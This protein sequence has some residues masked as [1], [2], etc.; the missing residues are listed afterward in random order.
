[1]EDVFAV[2]FECENCGMEWE[3]TYPRRTAVRREAHYSAIVALDEDCSE[4]IQDCDC[5]HREVC[6]NCDLREHV[7]VSNR[8]PLEE[9]EA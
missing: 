9:A 4:F 5:C 8:R 7:T 2:E 3:E 1:M 6:P